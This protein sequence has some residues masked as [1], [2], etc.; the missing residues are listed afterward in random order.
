MVKDAPQLHAVADEIVRRLA[1]CDYTGYNVKRFDLPFL[2]AELDLAGGFD[3]VVVDAMTI[4]HHFEKRD[5]AAAC[6]TYLGFKHESTHR[7]LPDALAALHVLQAQAYRHFT[8]EATPTTPAVIVDFVRDPDAI[9]DDGKFKFYGDDVRITFGKHR[10]RTLK[11]M[12]KHER[13]FLQWMLG[14]SDFAED[15]KAVARNALAGVMPKK[16]ETKP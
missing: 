13:G 6:E 10:G 9:D 1:G 4:F 15:S 11:W 2:K 8:D 12:L 7:A 16:R 5:L 3:G 14:I